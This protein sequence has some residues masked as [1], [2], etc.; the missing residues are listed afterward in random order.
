MAGIVALRDDK[1]ER[2]WVNPAWV[3]MVFDREGAGSTIEF[4]DGHQ[5][6]LHG[7]A[8]R[9]VRALNQAKP[10]AAAPDT[11]DASTDAP[12]EAVEVIKAARAA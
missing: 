3:K 9:V 12:V 4:M 7:P 1:G 6:H 2:V 5:L 10:E 8:R 11:A